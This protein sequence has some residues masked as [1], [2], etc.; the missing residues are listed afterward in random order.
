[1]AMYLEHS[2]SKCILKVSPFKAEVNVP[3]GL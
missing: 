2:Q 3:E 1:M